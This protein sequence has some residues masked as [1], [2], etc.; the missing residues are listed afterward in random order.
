MKSG[1][2]H[3]YF[4]NQN[5]TCNLKPKA[6]EAQVQSNPLKMAGAN[7]AHREARDIGAMSR[8]TRASCMAVT[9]ATFTAMATLAKECLVLP[10]I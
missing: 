1:N 3:C 8:N 7:G 4:V 5:R 10:V 9:V 2:I 6:C